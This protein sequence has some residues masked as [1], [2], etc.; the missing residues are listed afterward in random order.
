M[1]NR[2]KGSPI[3]QFDSTIPGVPLP[4][5]VENLI[6]TCLQR[7]REFGLDYYPPVCEMLEFDHMSEVAAYNGFPVRYPHWRFGMEYEDLA[8]RYNYGMQRIYEMVINTSPFCYIY[9]LKSND[10][11]D[12]VTVIVHALGHSHFFKNN[13]YFK[14][15]DGNMMN[16]M[17]DNGS[18]IRRYMARWGRDKVTKFID[19]VLRIQTLID[20]SSGW[21]IKKVSQVIKRDSRTFREMRRFKVGEDRSYLDDWINT[22]EWKEFERKRIE[23]EDIAEQL[24]LFGDPERDIFKYLRDHCKFKPWEQDIISMLY[25]ES[26]YFAP[27]GATKVINEG[28]ASW[29]DYKMIACEGMAALGQK[30]PDQGI[31][32]YA[33][34]KMGVLGGK[35]SMNPYKLGFSILMDIEERWN[36]GKFG[37]EW[38]DCKDLREREKWDKKL[39]QGKEKVFEVVDLEN[40][41]TL[42]AKYF[43]QE[44]CAKMEFF[45]SKWYPNGLKKLEG[46]DYKNIK[47]KLLQRHIHRGLPDIRLTDP[48][49]M[50]KGWFLMQHFADKD[51]LRPLHEP[52]LK[53]VLP[54]IYH[55]WGNTVVLESRTSAGEPI[56]WACDGDTPEHVV[57]MKRSEY[58]EKYLK[59]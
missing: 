3:L 25:G 21:D 17:A 9:L 26:L 27:Q 14:P 35:Y 46:R 5:E 10:L 32:H 23:K 31:I 28:F 19:H 50:N 2:L 53:E 57:M 52:Y 49:H 59:K 11:I 37:Q 55:L 6:P 41:F 44:L 33:K 8:H 22:P 34:H 36:K 56:V 38:D 15:T 42:I 54:S 51:D 24:D 47:T 1:P 29:V 45:E 16:I 18:R 4:K 40:D 39:G 7:C 48:N 30:H 12:H 13:I 20:P 43:T 58:E